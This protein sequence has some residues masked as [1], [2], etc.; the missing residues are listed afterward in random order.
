[1]HKLYQKLDPEGKKDFEMIELVED[2]FIGVLKE[3]DL[4]IFV[5]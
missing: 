5:R 4:L 2:S 1:M 3:R